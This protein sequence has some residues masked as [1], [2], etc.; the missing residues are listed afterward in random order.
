MFDHS[1]SSSVFKGNQISA[2]YHPE[3]GV[4]SHNAFIE[5]L[6]A[7]MEKSEVARRILRLPK[8]DDSQRNW[9]EI[10]RLHAVQTIANYIEP[11]PLHIGLTQRFSTMI[12]NGY[13]ARNPLSDEWVKQIRAG[14][15]AM[16]WWT[17]ENEPPPIQST[18]A[19]FAIVGTSG[20]GKTTA[21]KSV[22][23]LYPQ[24]IFHSEYNGQPF[25]RT[26]LVWL[27]L[28]CP[29]NG[30]VRGLCQNFFYTIDQI[31]GTRYYQ[32]FDRLAERKTLQSMAHIASLLG[33]GVLVID[34]IQRVIQ[35]KSGESE[36]MLDLFVELANTIGVPVVLIGTYEALPLVTKAF[37]PARRGSGQGDMLL[38]NME[39]DE[40][41]NYLI[42]NMWRL[43]WT[44][45]P[46]ELTDEILETLYDESQGIIDIAAKLYMLAQWSVI[47]Q[48]SERL[49]PA[50]FRS[51][52]KENLRLVR[53]ILEAMRKKDLKVLSQISDVIPNPID[54]YG[55]LKQAEER[56]QVEGS[57]NT[58]RVQNI[59]EHG[60]NN[61]EF[62]IVSWLI[63]AGIDPKL[64]AECASRAVQLHANS[65]NIEEAMRGAMK[66]AL[67]RIEENTV[68][69]ETQ[70]IQ[71]AKTVKKKAARTNTTNPSQDLREI[72]SSGKKCGIPAYEAL[73]EAEVIKPIHEL[74]DLT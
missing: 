6:P 19:G 68:P 54:L 47:G 20:V 17:D 40:T 34:E 74:V 12:K 57:L 37:S 59:T 2:R 7:N 24:V 30:S 9:S 56:V 71:T 46:T 11:L 62:E 63:T 5:A 49:N 50:R 35:G 27:H 32:K 58:L 26:Q 31:L 1:Q 8:W 33:L 69:E 10:R 60:T 13:I 66:M 61:P 48:A 23:G 15:D 3:D 70:V 16:D 25:N 44:N 53:P 45:E 72:V 29:Y 64:A 21:V 43:Q 55:H 28:E 22:L 41:W 42:S 73:K 38:S 51:V 36:P 14:Y 4:Y 52:A 65:T 39:N 18:A 67:Q